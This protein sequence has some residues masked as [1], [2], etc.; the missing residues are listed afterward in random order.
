M[1]G[2]PG[3]G[4]STWL[5]QR[6]ANPVSSD[7]IRLQLADDET[8]Q[9]INGRVF[10]T[11]RYLVWQRIAVGRPVTFVDATHITRRERRPYFKIAAES[12]CAISALWFD[13]PLGVCR[14]RNAARGRV[15]P[16]HVMDRMAALLVPP[17][18]AEGFENI[19]VVK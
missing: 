12:G 10:E 15:V 16:A 18:C 13:T 7:A 14:T 8:D 17:S 4:K 6:G 5:R 2:L 3:S 19:Q 11:I 9:S 1:V